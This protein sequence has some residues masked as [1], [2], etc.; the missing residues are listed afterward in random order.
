[1]ERERKQGN[2]SSLFSPSF[3]AFF[4]P[5]SPF[6]KK[7]KHFPKN[8][9]L[10]AKHAHTC[11][12]SITRARRDDVTTTIDEEEKRKREKE[13]ERER[14]IERV[15]FFPL[16]FFF[17][18]FSLPSLSVIANRPRERKR[19]REREI[20][21]E[22]FFSFV[23]LLLLFFPP[24]PFCYRKSSELWFACCLFLSY[25]CVVSLP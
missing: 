19:E 15:F 17:F 1:M 12:P 23:V 5:E 21:R 11:S 4:L 9:P 7:K 13:R 6:K 10:H 16:L 20:S 25:F 8:A 14:N 3:A 2:S 22:F 18:F 24:L